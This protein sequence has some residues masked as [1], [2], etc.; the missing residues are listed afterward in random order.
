MNK[1]FYAILPI[2]LGGATLNAH[3]VFISQVVDHPALNSTVEG[4]RAGLN[5]QGFE[6]NKNLE[7]K[8][9]SAQANAA[10]AGQIA[11]KFANQNPDVVV[12]VGTLSAQSFL[13]YALKGQVKLVFS[14]ITDPKSAGLTDSPHIQGVSN[15]IALEPQLQLFQKIQPNLKTLGILYNPGELNSIEIVKKLKELCPKF[16]IALFKQ[17]ITKTSE[18][19]QAAQKLAPQVDAIFI[20]NDN[21]ALSALQ[22]IVKV[23]KP[24]YVSDTDA[25]ALGAVAAF[26]PNQYE[27]GVQTGVM[28]ARLLNGE[29]TSPSIEYP[30]KSDLY[31]NLEAANKLGLEIPDEVLKNATKILEEAAL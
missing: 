26:G 16:G 23:G 22:S 1:L 12:G 19:P 28:I 17:T 3:S 24:V 21:T 5:S 11:G 20:S 2:F 27:V 8:I 9:E 30:S 29:M 13:K 18:V 15:F 7:I 14:S 6:E 31:I 10:M 25:V 4:L